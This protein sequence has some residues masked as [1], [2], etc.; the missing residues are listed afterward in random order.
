MA[1]PALH[2]GRG[3]VMKNRGCW[4][5]TGRHFKVNFTWAVRVTLRFE[6]DIVLGPLVTSLNKV[7]GGRLQY[8]RKLCSPI[9]IYKMRYLHRKQN[10][11]N[12]GVRGAVTR[13]RRRPTSTPSHPISH[14]APRGDARA[15]K[16][17]ILNMVHGYAKGHGEIRSSWGQSENNIARFGRWA[18]IAYRRSMPIAQKNELKKLPRCIEFSQHMC[19]Y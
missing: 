2:W 4:L 8:T 12:G 5:A 6:T 3:C 7:S 10:K 14:T 15:S 17:A 11:K 1:I 9:T 13:V 18:S 16:S 19:T